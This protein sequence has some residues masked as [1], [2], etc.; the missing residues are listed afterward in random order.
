[1]RTPSAG[2]R[3]CAAKAGKELLAQKLMRFFFEIPLRDHGVVFERRAREAVEM[4]AADVHDVRRLSRKLY[5]LRQIRIRRAS[6]ML[7]P[8][9][10]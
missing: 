6:S 8:A 9:S 4:H 7:V 3:N 2:E 1:M 5:R 10:S